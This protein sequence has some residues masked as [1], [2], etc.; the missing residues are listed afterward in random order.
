MDTGDLTLFLSVLEHRSFTSAAREHGLSKQNLSR[1][2][3][4]LE[5]QV[6][7]PLLSRTTRSVQATEAGSI[8]RERARAVLALLAD[9]H[10]AHEHA[11]SA[12]AGRVRLT[13]DPVV[14]E[15]LTPTLVALLERHPA[16]SLD[17]EITRRKLDL[18]E[19]G[20]DVAVRVG[21]VDDERLRAIAL[22]PAAVRYCASPRY[23]AQR[24][25]PR[26]PEE[27]ARHDLVAAAEGPLRWPVLRDGR[28]ELVSAEAR[29]RTTSARLAH[30]AVVAG[31]GIGLFP[32]HVVERDLAEQRLVPVLAPAEIRVGSLW[33][34]HPPARI[35]L[36]RVRAVVD[37]IRQVLGQRSGARRSSAASAS[38]AV[39]RG[40]AVRKTSRK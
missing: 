40:S 23:V 28:L 27:L 5:A 2:I 7:A 34:V 30:E 17:V 16:L 25:A 15:L 35:Q 3:A 14:G 20:F 21:T 36:A 13:A 11:R 33:L 24:G 22:G 19:E 18:V 8:Y 39:R 12:V 4:R 37:A 31:A 26:T 1:R 29:V 10:A 9:A 32:V 6:G 38:K